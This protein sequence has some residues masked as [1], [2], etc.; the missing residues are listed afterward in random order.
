MM[1]NSLKCKELRYIWFA[2]ATSRNGEQGVLTP[3]N[4][5]LM[6]RNVRDSEIN[7]AR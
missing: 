3:S 4:D 1:R 7:E 6:D 5:V 2:A